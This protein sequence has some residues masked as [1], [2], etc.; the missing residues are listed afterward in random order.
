M[1]GG[2]VC[3]GAL[4]VGAPSGRNPDASVGPLE[5][6]LAVLRALAGARGQ[7]LRPA[8]LVRVTCLARSPVDRIA[9]TLLRL[10]YLR[11]E[12]GGALVLTPRVLEFGLAYLRACR[13]PQTLGPLAEALAD[14]LDESVS[15]AV[16]DGDAAR[17]VVQT[18]R[19]RA[20]SVTFHTGD[21]LPADRCAA[22]IVFAAEVGDRGW[23]IDDQLV[24][25][26]LVAVAVPVRDATG[27]VVCALSVASHTSRHS[28]ES[29]RAR[30]LEPMLQ[31]AERMAAALVAPD[32][33]PAAIASGRDDTSDL[34]RELGPEYLQS[35]ARGL[36]VLVALAVPGGMTLTA[37]AEATALPRATA[38]RSLLT[39]EHLG[40]VS[41]DGRHFTPCPRVLDLG[42]A[43]VSSRSLAD[44]AAPHL[45]GLVRR[46]HE[47]ASVAVLDGPDI[48]YVAR[49]A[50]SRIMQADITVGTRFPAHATSMG[51]V[52]LAGL[53]PAKRSAWLAETELR[54]L[55]PSTV[56]D[57][58]RLEAILSETGRDGFA[59][60]D[61]E[62]D[63]G[64]RSIA[65]PLHGPDGQVVAALNVSLNAG[66]T[67]LEAVPG[68]LLPA[69]QE[70]AA[71]ISEDISLVFALHPPRRW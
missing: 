3:D 54:P 68:L 45:A 35:L 63:E 1:S 26:G 65:V 13:L 31:A 12:D 44:V 2:A 52:L 25:P 27:H 41:F 8:E 30:A 70:T 42:Y 58:A 9:A 36:S 7:R 39:L 11:E 19:R 10:G 40:Y 32:A 18:P 29:L 48:R 49:I 23:A 57:P 15:L 55:T 61:Q 66:R 59:L 56:T 46:V 37:V 16:P 53:L 67:S 43:T 71:R 24:E 20:L 38:R 4:S 47:S 50:A 21:A 5:R 60:V 14:E 17:F 69:L 51:R 62:L 34:K 33:R 64:L 22:G 6:G 28:A